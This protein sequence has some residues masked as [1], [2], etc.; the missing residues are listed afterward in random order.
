MRTDFTYEYGGATINR[1]YKRIM[2]EL[3]RCLFADLTV[4]EAYQVVAQSY[5]RPIEADSYVGRLMKAALNIP[6]QQQ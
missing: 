1:F 5:R 6:P 3:W 4:E 2:R